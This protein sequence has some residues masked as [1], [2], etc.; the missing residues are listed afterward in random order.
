MAQSSVIG[1]L[2]T[3][4]LIKSKSNLAVIC[5][6]GSEQTLVFQHKVEL[7]SR[8][9]SK[10][11][12]NRLKHVLPKVIS[13]ARSTFVPNQLIIDNTTIAYELLHKMRNKSKGKVGQMTV[14]LDINKAYDCVELG[15]L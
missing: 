3:F 8:I 13:E 14:K 9:L 2:C 12:A 1:S 5:N 4:T 11:I 15:F 10:V 7:S 6:W